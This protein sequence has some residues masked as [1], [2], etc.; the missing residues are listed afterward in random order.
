MNPDGF[1]LVGKVHKT[2]GTS[3][4]LLLI[5]ES[6]HLLK[7]KKKEPVFL[8]LQ[9]K[10]VPFFIQEIRPK[11]KNQALAK[12]MDTEALQESISLLNAEIFLPNSRK[13]KSRKSAMLEYDLSGF[14]VI[15]ETFGYL[16]IVEGIIELPMQELLEIN[17]NGKQILVPIVEG[18]ILGIDARRKTI[19]TEIP[20]GLLE[21]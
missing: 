3:G 15:D 14:S 1:F 11:A 2:F 6:D 16:G 20:E 13:P 9:G 4:E 5:L 17:Y 12:F 19:N 21:L 7:L 8:L 18:I 10:P